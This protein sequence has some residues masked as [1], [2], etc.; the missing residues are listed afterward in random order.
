VGEG[1]TGTAASLTSDTGY[2]WFFSPTNAEVVVKVLNACNFDRHFWVFAG[3]LTNVRV[4]M[5]VEDTQTGQVKSYSNLQGKAFQPIQDTAAFSTCNG[6][7]LSASELQS[8]GAIKSA[9][10]GLVRAPRKNFLGP[11]VTVSPSRVAALASSLTA[12]WSAEDVRSLHESFVLIAPDAST[13]D[14]F[15]VRTKIFNDLVAV[16][17]WLRD[18]ATPDNINCNSGSVYIFRRDQGGANHWGLVKKLLASDAQCGALLGYSLDLS[19]DTLVV[20]AY[21]AQSA[22][23]AAYVFQRNFGGPDNW[24]QTAKLAV[25]GQGTPFFG[26]SVKL[27]GNDLAI[28]A[29]ADAYLCPDRPNFCLAGLVYFYHRASPADPSWVLTNIVRAPNATSQ[30][31]FGES[32]AADDGTFVVSAFGANNSDGL[33]YIYQRTGERIDSWQLVKIITPGFATKPDG[34]WSH[35][36][37]GRW[38][39]A[40]DF[41]DDVIVGGSP[42]D[43]RFCTGANYFCG[44]VH[45]FLRNPGP[46]STWSETQVLSPPAPVTGIYFGGSVGLDKNLLVAFNGAETGSADLFQRNASSQWILESVLLPSDL[47]ASG[48]AVSVYSGLVAVGA[49][50]SDRA[51]RDH[52][53]CDA[54]ATYLFDYSAEKHQCQSDAFGLCLSQRRFRVTTSYRTHAAAGPGEASQ[55]TSDTGYFWF[56]NSTN[57]ELLVKVLDGCGVNDHFWVFAGGLTNVAVEIGITDTMTGVRKLY[58]SPLDS[59]FS[60]LQDTL[61]F[62]CH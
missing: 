37:L 17:A 28:G 54:G 44:S 40:L 20:G 38:P 61:A 60:P 1:G 35:G 53:S 47:P 6:N 48:E 45:V 5:R 24:G 2:F 57:I 12:Q 7:D 43:S 3:G 33:I 4:D 29:P 34:S 11:P 52:Q 13:G 42:L 41:Q 22:Q 50:E 27:N 15:G 36:L 25:P 18:D 51:C 23:G 21:G 39:D 26:T 62:P 31:S 32:I 9:V 58:T 14:Q 16:G 49:F 56:F 10:T 8:D 59:A 55:L 30:D 19:G 46:S